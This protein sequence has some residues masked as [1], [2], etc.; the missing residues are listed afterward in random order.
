MANKDS[1]DSQ[2]TPSQ[3]YCLPEHYYT[4]TTPEMKNWVL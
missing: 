1:Q 2:Y 4:F 3:S